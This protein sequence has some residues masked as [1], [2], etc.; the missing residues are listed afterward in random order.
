MINKI[1]R[2]VLVVVIVICA[3]YWIY[4]GNIFWSVYCILAGLA[5]SA[6]LLFVK[7]KKE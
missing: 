1:L 7:E 2:L 6:V 5:N 3:C 4:Q